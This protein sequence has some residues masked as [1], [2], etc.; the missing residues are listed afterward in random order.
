MANFDVQ[1]GG[2]MIDYDEIQRKHSR[3]LREREKHAKKRCERFK[4]EIQQKKPKF[5]LNRKAKKVIAKNKEGEILG[6]FF[7][8]SLAADSVCVGQSELSR[9]LKKKPDKMFKGFFWEVVI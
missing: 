3:R 6:K 2:I 8:I 7:S 5:K 1:K 9:H 4:I